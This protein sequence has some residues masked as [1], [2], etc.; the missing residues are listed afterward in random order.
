MWRYWELLTDLSLPEIA[1]EHHCGQPCGRIGVAPIEHGI[2]ARAER[3]VGV[4]QQAHDERPNLADPNMRALR[5]DM[6]KK[7]EGF[8]LATVS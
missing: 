4:G 8:Q 3:Q 1:A 2:H 6:L 5:S 7:Y